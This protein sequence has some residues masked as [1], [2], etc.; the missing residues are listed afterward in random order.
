MVIPALNT[1]VFSYVTRTTVALGP[2]MVA[3]VADKLLDWDVEVIHEAGCRKWIARD[4]QG[5][6]DHEA[7][8][9]ERSADAVGFY[10][11]ISCSM[12]RLW[13]VAKFYQSQK[14]L[15]VAG[16]LHSHYLP[17]E[18]LQNGIDLVVHGS[19]EMMIR[20]ILQRFKN[21]ETFKE[22]AGITF[23]HDGKVFNTPAPATEI[24]QN[25]F[26]ENLPFPDFGLIRDCKIKEYPIG[27]IRGCSMNC[28]FCSVKGKP[29][30]FSPEKLFENVRWL[31]ETRRAKNFFLVDDRMEEDKEGTIRFFELI[32]NKYGRKLEIYV[33]TRLEA[34][35]DQEFIALMRDAG[36]RRVFIGYESPIDDEL[37]AM[38]KG[39]RSADMLEWTK[40]YH[41][42]GFFVHAMFIFGYPGTQT[43]SLTA[44]KRM[45]ELK[46]FIRRA[47]LDSI[48]ILKPIP[49]PG[50]ELRDRLEKSGKLLPL[51]VVP[52]EMYD[53]NHVNIIPNDKEMTL[54]ELQ[55]YPMKIMSW[56]YHSRSFLRIGFR[57]IIMPIDYLLRGWQSWYHGWWNDI[58]RFGGNRILEKWKKRNDEDTFVRKIENWLRE[59]KQSLTT[60]S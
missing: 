43:C 14:V 17:E 31:V 38:R 1:N 48:Q 35:R 10:G 24:K 50:S 7:L 18:S 16:G 27:R 4:A 22:L 40:I 60:N 58:V 46:K 59:R 11:G 39:Y 8:Q 33:Q 56:F 53:G 3:T 44:K 15:T 36:V 20:E 57:T 32:K 42:F 34:A 45:E 41:R 23:L 37:R 55:K 5:N 51:E 19:G 49:L 54:E 9:K 30:W 12:P 21:K 47:K 29:C 6:I 13:D 52:W 2:I 28:E 26:L 25:T